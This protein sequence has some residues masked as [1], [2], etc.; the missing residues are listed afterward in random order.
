MAWRVLVALDGS[1]WSD[2]AADAA[3][4]LAENAGDAIRLSALH[5]VN[6]TRVRGRWLE[7]LGGLLGLEPV[8]VP[9]AVEAYFKAR[10]EEV[11]K[12]FVD[13]AADRG[14]TV[15]T[16]LDQ[17]GVVERVAHHGGT[18]DLV[19]LG[20]RGETEEDL[21]G[22]GGTTVERTLRHLTA[23]ALV[24]PGPLPA[25]T[26]IAV[27]VDGS[28]GA[29]RGLLAAAHLAELVPV[30]LHLIHVGDHAPDPDPLEEARAVLD[31]RSVQIFTHRTDGEAHEALPAEAAR[32]GCN[33]L[34]LGFRGR[35]HLKD[36]FLGRITEWMVGRV[37]LALLIGR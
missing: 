6:V 36:V 34:A 22:L 9:E 5:V 30:P 16:I 11:L 15:H 25:I 14:A 31:G 23:S 32:L 33:V 8:V 19:V 35:S 3:L 2:G 1:R 17:G 13:R 10:G 24:V 26:G 18:A 27:G 29:A 37:D 7:D 12:T 20:V 4:W 28:P 21:T